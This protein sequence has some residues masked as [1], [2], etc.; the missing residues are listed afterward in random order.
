MMR[1]EVVSL[2]DIQTLN[3]FF[4]SVLFF[5]FGGGVFLEGGGIRRK[6]LSSVIVVTSFTYRYLLNSSSRVSDTLPVISSV[7]VFTK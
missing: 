4:D 6:F 1:L 7:D 2:L 3:V 5:F